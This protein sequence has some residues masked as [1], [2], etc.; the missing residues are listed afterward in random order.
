MFAMSLVVI[1]AALAQQPTF[2][3][4]RSDQS[5]DRDNH[6]RPDELDSDAYRRSEN[7][8]LGRA[9]QGEI[10]RPGGDF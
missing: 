6:Y 4:G 5:D 8:V 7:A 9:R 3:D 2:R 1:S 10:T